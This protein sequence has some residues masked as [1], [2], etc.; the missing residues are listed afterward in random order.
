MGVKAAIESVLRDWCITSLFSSVKRCVRIDSSEHPG[1][2]ILFVF[3]VDDLLPY[4]PSLPPSLSFSL[5]PAPSLAFS[6]TYSFVHSSNYAIS[7]ILYRLKPSCPGY[8][9]TPIKIARW[10]EEN[11][12]R[13]LKT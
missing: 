10:S 13:L 5:T 7:E 2:S 4:F 6:L 9:H 3:L 11:K 1:V 8:D 12:I